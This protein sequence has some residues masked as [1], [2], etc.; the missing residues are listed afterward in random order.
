VKLLQL[1]GEPREKPEARE[2]L[3]QQVED[4]LDLLER[5]VV[6][7]LRL[8]GDVAADL[9]SSD[10]LVELRDVALRR[11]DLVLPSLPKTLRTFSDEIDRQW[12]SPVGRYVQRSIRAKA[13]STRGR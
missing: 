1:R 9:R 7:L 5:A 6:D 4:R 12:T 11:L 13:P 10:L 3:A 2:P 8:A